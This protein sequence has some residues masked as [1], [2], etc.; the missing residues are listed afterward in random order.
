MK[1]YIFNFHFKK[2]VI[3]VLI[4]IASAYLTCIIVYEDYIKYDYKTDRYYSNRVYDFSKI[5]SIRLRKKMFVDYMFLIIETENREI[6][7]N[8]NELIELK[9]KNILTSDELD[10]INNIEKV[11]KMNLSEKSEDI[12][13]NEM[14]NRV[15]IIPKELAITQT[16]I[17]SGWGTSVFAKKANNMFGHW[18]YQVGTG[19]VPTR[20]D[21]GQTHEIAIFNSVNDSVKKYM[22]NLNTNRAYQHLRLLRSELRDANEDIRGEILSAGL[23]NYSGIGSDYIKMIN[24]IVRDISRYWRLDD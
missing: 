9:N 12:D 14:L 24:S 23:L 17:E 18:T 3:T 10:F 22:L 5:R 15:D 4:L 7:A 16:A 2:I 21:A 19:L 20:R 13:W 1:E 11:Y 8:R 6:L